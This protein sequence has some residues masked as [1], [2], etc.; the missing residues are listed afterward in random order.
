MKQKIEI[1][2][3]RHLE[4]LRNCGGY[5]SCP[6][7]PNGERLGPLV[8][9]AGKYDAP[10]PEDPKR[11]LQ[12]VGDV[13]AN[14]SKAE[15]HPHVL[16]FFAE[17]L[18]CRL[19]GEIGLKNIGG[20]VSAPIG[21]Y[22]LADALGLAYQIFDINII[23]A[24]KKVTALAT[25]ELREQSKLIFARHNIEPGLGCVIVE[26]VC[27]NFSTT[28]ELISLIRSAGGNVLA[29]ACFLNRS[30][31]VDDTYLYGMEA[32]AEPLKIPVISLVRLPIDEWRQ[33]DSEV[34]SDIEAGNVVLKPKDK[35]EW[36]RLM[37]AM[38]AHPAL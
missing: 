10:I 11:K 13:Y 5:Y 32:K 29:I 30:L 24:E 25:D 7:A 37:R 26:D 23:K 3:N 22:S 27:N 35:D 9:Y 34:A 14:F 1:A 21:G 6:T 38:S 17:A 19:E 4:T 20:F 33:D 31:D 18:C 12:F 16:A 8:G 2:G 36:A 28:N 15:V